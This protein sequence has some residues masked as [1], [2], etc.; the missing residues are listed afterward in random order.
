METWLVLF[1]PLGI[2]YY[3]YRVLRGK[4]TSEI[5]MV[6]KLAAKNGWQFT[7]RPDANAF[8][9]FADYIGIQN[10]A[11]RALYFVSGDCNGKA[12]ELFLLMGTSKPSRSGPYRSLAIAYATVVRTHEELPT[13]TAPKDK[14]STTTYKGWNYI[15]YGANAMTEPEILGLLGLME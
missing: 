9:D 4:L 2:L 5:D 14:V 3:A 13:L 7:K 8:A 11:M 6:Q 12:F 15:V 10:D 1:V